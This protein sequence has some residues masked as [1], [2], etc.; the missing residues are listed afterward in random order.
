MEVDRERGAVHGSREDVKAMRE[1][2]ICGSMGVGTWL[3]S[4]KRDCRANRPVTPFW[5]AMNRSSADED[6]AVGVSLMFGLGI[7]LEGG[8]WMNHSQE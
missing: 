8:Y 1:S 2:R 6:A 3:W 5:R 7:V 4:F